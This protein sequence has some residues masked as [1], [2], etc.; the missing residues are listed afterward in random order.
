MCNLTGLVYILLRCPFLF[1]G[2]LSPSIAVP[3]NPLELTIQEQHELGYMPF[4]DDF[5][6]VGYPGV[7]FEGI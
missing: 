6:R 5:E 1:T 3:V 2:P 4:R 7:N